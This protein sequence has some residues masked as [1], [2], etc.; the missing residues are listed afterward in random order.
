MSINPQEL[1]IGNIVI[2]NG[3]HVQVES[4]CEYGI[5]VD[6]C[7]VDGDA[8][9]S[10][11]YNFD[12]LEPILLTPEIL[13]KVGFEKS[14]DQFGGYLVDIG[15]D[16]QIRVINNGFTYVWPLYGNK[17]VVVTYLHQLQN[18]TFALTGQELPIN[19]LNL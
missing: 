15:M 18:L 10:A 9:L 12:D 6:V 17:E 3:K 14:S 1:R 11:E 8:L 7:S 16:E 2:A 19:D 13:E 5:N 4:I